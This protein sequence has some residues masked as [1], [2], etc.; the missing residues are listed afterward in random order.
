MHKTVDLRRRRRCAGWRRSS[1]SHRWISRTPIDSMG[2]CNRISMER[3][4]HNKP[5]PLSLRKAHYDGDD[6]PPAKLGNHSVDGRESQN[7]KDLRKYN[8]ER[9]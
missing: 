1:G 7:M 9:D 3:H 2:L 5:L 6:D 8:R 4:V